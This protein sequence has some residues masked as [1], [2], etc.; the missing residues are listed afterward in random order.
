MSTTHLVTAEELWNDGLEHCELVDGVLIPMTPAGAEHGGIAG[1]IIGKLYLHITPKKLG[2][3]FTAETGFILS[4][5]PDT[6]RA[7]D[8]SFVSAASLARSG[9]PKGFFS[10]PPDLAIEIISPRDRLVDVHAKA[11]AWL[12]A[13]CRMVWV[14]HPSRRSVELFRSGQAVV[15]FRDTDMLPGH[16]VVPGFECPVAEI[17]PSREDT[18]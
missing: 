4:R 14:I 13:G 6:V 11:N 9:V 18:E 10:G 7:P 12:A 15:S 2:R 3:L 16:D 1:E 8:V 17:F 5:D